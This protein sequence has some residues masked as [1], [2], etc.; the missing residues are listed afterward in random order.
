MAMKLSLEPQR[1][2]GPMLFSVACHLERPLI[3]ASSLWNW[4]RRAAY[5]LVQDR[6]WIPKQGE[7]CPTAGIGETCIG[8]GAIYV[9]KILKGAKS[10]DLPVEQPTKIELVVNLKAAKRSD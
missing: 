9:D 4:Q 8:G 5:P 10:G 2:K 7:L 1:R 6:I 3:G